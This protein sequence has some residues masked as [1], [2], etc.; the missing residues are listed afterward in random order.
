MGM[1]RLQYLRPQGHQRNCR[2][3][4]ALKPW[5]KDKVSISSISS[6]NY[7]SKGRVIRTLGEI[8]TL[9]I[10]GWMACDF[11]SFSTV[12]QSY[13]DNGYMIMKA[14]CNVTLFTVEKISPRV[15]LEPGTARSVGQR[16]I[17]CV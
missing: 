3:A 5:W 16:R 7:F 9:E 11:T 14:V 15:G 6:Q 8:L 4:Q 1:V 2:E 12:F 10:D 17:N 13:Q